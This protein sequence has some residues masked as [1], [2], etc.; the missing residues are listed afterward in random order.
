MDLKQERIDILRGAF[1]QRA[2]D[3][4]LH[5]INI[6]NFTAA[7]DAITPDANENLRSFAQELMQR[8]GCELAQQARERVMLKVIEQQLEAADVR[9]A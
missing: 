7:I 3:V 8:L 9:S 5:Q 1:E 4:M 2:R 6:D